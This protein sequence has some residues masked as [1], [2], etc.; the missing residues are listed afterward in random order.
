MLYLNKQAMKKGTGDYWSCEI[1]QR[2]PGEKGLKGI[3]VKSVRERDTGKRIIFLMPLQKAS[4]PL[5]T[6]SHPSS[7]TTGQETPNT[8]K[9][10]V[11]IPIA[12]E[13]QK[14]YKRVSPLPDKTPLL[15]S[16][17][18]E[19]QWRG[20]SPTAR[21]TGHLV[22]SPRQTSRWGDGGAFAIIQSRCW[23]RLAKLLPSHTQVFYFRRERDRFVVMLP[24]GFWDF[25]CLF[26]LNNLASYASM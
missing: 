9:V 19:S 16:F 24:L 26:F 23:L 17:P 3:Y 21:G 20:Y 13:D 25:V 7:V 18:Q 12:H 1:P 11:K 10:R 14:L 15:F 8:L 6:S 4:P 2:Y 22:T 5:A